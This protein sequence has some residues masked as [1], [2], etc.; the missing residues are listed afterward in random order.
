MAALSLARAS[1]RVMGSVSLVR[2]CVSWG[3]W[4]ALIQLRPEATRQAF[5]GARLDRRG[6]S[7]DDSQMSP[8]RA[9][10]MTLHEEQISFYMELGYAITQWAHVEDHV[11][12]IV[13]AGIVDD[14]NR[15]AV[16]VGFVSI[17]GFRAK[18]DF[19]EAVVE[20]LLASRRPEERAAWTKL[21]HRTRRAS[22]QRNKLAHW[23]V[24]HYPNGRVGRRYA[25]EAWVQTKAVLRK[26][27]NNPKDGALCVRDVVKL[28]Q[29]FSALTCALANFLSRL[30]GQKEP[31][32]KSD[33]QPENPPTIA[34]LKR[35][36][37][38]GF[39]PRRRGP[40]NES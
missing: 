18:M 1:V 29:E 7:A 26:N 38:E 23:R 34:M 20:R 14:L 21:V 2:V 13:A 3:C 31:F 15:K 16:N 30:A 4:P 6:P 40:L 9:M 8:F 24:L 36:I 12:A 28:K 37:R 11:R 35:R 32:P 22:Y 19:A 17:D 5:P 27:K 33:E 10:S 25:L 39:V